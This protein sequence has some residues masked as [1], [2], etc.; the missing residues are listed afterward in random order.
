[1]PIFLLLLI[2]SSL[3]AVPSTGI[4][5]TQIGALDLSGWSLEDILA[6][7]ERFLLQAALPIIV[8]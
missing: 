5:P 4:D 2:P 7:I 3:F 8:V 6:Y 1:M